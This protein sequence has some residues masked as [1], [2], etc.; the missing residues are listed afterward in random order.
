MA[1]AAKPLAEKPGRF[2]TLPRVVVMLAAAALSWASFADASLAVGR[3]NAPAFVLGAYPEDPFLAPALAQAKILQ[4]KGSSAAREEAADLA[5]LSVKNHALNPE[6]LRLIAFSADEGSASAE[7][8]IDLSLRMSRRDEMAQLFKALKSAERDDMEAAY[9]YFDTAIQ[10][11]RSARPMIYPILANAM[12]DARFRAGFAV[13]LERNPPWVTEFLHHLI[14]EN[15]DPTVGARLII[16]S[17]QTAD[18]AVYRELHADLL[19]K[20]VDAKQFGLA[21][22]VFSRMKGVDNRVLTS[23]GLSKSAFDERNGAF[24]WRLVNGSAIGAD[25]VSSNSDTF[26][27]ETFATSGEKDTVA[28]KILFLRPAAYRLSARVS[29]SAMPKGGS[30]QMSVDCLQAGQWAQIARF[31]MDNSTKPGAVS[32]PFVVSGSCEAQKVGISVSGGSGFEELTATVDRI[33]I[34]QLG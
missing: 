14:R 17:P 9:K 21:R 11:S 16:E 23:V 30:M 2:V 7:A 8:A 32:L 5:V 19:A 10:T 12:K 13:I 18:T 27:L 20:L 22:Q 31:R 4:Q 26:A 34:S 6:A 24:G 15:T 29:K 25:A 28:S 1:L 33:E 3:K